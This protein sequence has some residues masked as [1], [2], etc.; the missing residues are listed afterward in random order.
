MATGTA[1][2][3]TIIESK[4]YIAVDPVA[5]NNKFWKYVRYSTPITEGGETGDLKVTWGRVG[6]DN[7][8]SQVRMYDE[9]FLAGKIRE[10]LKGKVDKA[11][12]KRVPYT[13]AQVMDHAASTTAGTPGKA[14][15]SEAV[16][17][18]AVQ[19][20]A[21]DCKIT[22][23]LI[24]KLAEANR[25]ELL[26][27]SGGQMD[28]DLETG[29]VRT[30]LGVVTSD[31]VTKARTLLDE[32]ASFVKKNKT[33]DAK[34]IDFLQQYLRL[35]PQKVPGKKGW[36]TSFI[37]M[38]AQTQLL[39]QLETSVELAE[40]RLKDAA[41]AKAAGTAETKIAPQV[42]NVKMTICEDAAVIAKIKRMFS[43]DG[44]ARHESARLK[45]VRIYEIEI[46][47]MATAFKSDGTKVGNVK[48]LWHGTRMFNVLSILKRGFVLP[49][50]LSTVQTT[51][52]MY[53]P[54]LYFSANSTKSLNYS[55]GYWDGGRRD[56]NCY[57]FLVDVAM[58]KEYLP[59]YSGNG[60]KPGYDSCWAKPGQSGVYNDE[61]I[62][63]RASQAN[64]RY[65]IEFDDK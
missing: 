25:H 30:P 53:G 61:Q 13:E 20:I 38:A 3:P 19:E 2:S 56:S 52:A 60:K 65:L 41:A 55:Y 59:S 40:Q 28:I 24:K 9:K 12:G 29:M 17:R 6:A 64:I 58:G 33:D 7:P 22:A 51:G 46:P 18:L 49:N 27:A 34:F 5:N 21:G 43:H 54:G 48:L 26:A 39:D 63:Y 50:Q 35:V 36:H 45:P 47:H 32:M 4:M 57:M 10:K 8:E 16:K 62:V 44:S 14:L 1:A 31:A 23:A 42:F 37:D 11:T 15:A